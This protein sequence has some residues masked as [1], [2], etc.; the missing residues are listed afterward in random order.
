MKM[1]AVRLSETLVTTY[2]TTWCYSISQKATYKV[3][4]INTIPSL[5]SSLHKPYTSFLKTPPLE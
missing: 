2:K 3:S 5:Q 1:E 4:T